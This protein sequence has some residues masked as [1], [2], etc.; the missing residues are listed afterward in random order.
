MARLTAAAAGSALT[1]LA[2]S[3]LWAGACIA[4]L[5][6]KP[7]LGMLFPLALICGRHWKALIASGLCAAVFASISALMLGGAA[8]TSFASFLPEFNRVA[9]EHGS[10]VWRATPTVFAAARIAGLSVGVAYVAHALI[11]IPAMAATGYLWLVRARFELKAA[12]LCLATLLA[13]PYLIYYDLA[14]L[15]L[16]I[17]FLMRDGERASL[18]RAEWC[19]IALAWLL[20][21]QGLFAVLAGFR[22]QIAPVFLVWFL[23]A[24]MLRHFSTTAHR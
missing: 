10:G 20:P 2:S 4:V 19:V 3:P 16:P 9:V 5:A 21:A 6:I 22:F 1:L 17:V 15:A 14:W 18:S 13:Q 7:Q 8:W 12:A 11:A 24:V 23:V